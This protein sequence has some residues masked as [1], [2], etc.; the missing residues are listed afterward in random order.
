MS[1]FK[2]AVDL[3]EETNTAWNDKDVNNIPIYEP[4]LSEIVAGRRNLFFSTG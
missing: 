1:N 3:N 2:S 4:V